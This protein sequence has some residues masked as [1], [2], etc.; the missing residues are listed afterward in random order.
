MNYWTAPALPP[1]N[2]S[3]GKI[4]QIIDE[5]C[6][7]YDVK[8]YQLQS[9]SRHHEITTPKHIL[10]YI[11]VKKVGLTATK[12]GKMFGNDHSNV[13]YGCKKIKGWMDVDKEFRTS[14]LGI[15]NKII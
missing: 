15:I 8:M 12:T 3:K 10:F 5:V 9:R 1:R 13:V 11:L 6:N 7:A 2:L 14:V 4:Q